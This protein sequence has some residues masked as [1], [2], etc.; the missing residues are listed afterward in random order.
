[1]RE[2]E[3]RFF[4]DSGVDQF[5]TSTDQRDFAGVKVGH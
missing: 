1:M 4:Y 3:V 2:F 5:Y